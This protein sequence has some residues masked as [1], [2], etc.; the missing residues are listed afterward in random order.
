[1]NIPMGR[2][3]ATAAKG[4]WVQV[5]KHV[6]FFL[7]Q[8][9]HL[10][11]K[12]YPCALGDLVELDLKDKSVS[13]ILPRKNI[14]MRKRREKSDQLVVAN[15]SCVVLCVS[16]F[17][18]RFHIQ[19]VDRVVAGLM[20]QSIPVEILITKKDLL[21]AQYLEWVIL[22]QNYMK[23]Y[24]HQE[25]KTL[26][27][28][29]EVQAHQFVQTIGVT[30]E[31]PVL[32]FIGPTG[33]GKSTLIQS[34]TGE[35]LEISEV[36]VKTGKGRHTTTQPQLYV[37]GDTYLADCPGIKTWFPNAE[38]L[39]ECFQDLLV[40]PVGFKPT[41]EDIAAFEED[42]SQGSISDYWRHC[43]DE[44]HL[45]IGKQRYNSYFSIIEESLKG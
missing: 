36:N 35:R 11:Q 13:N 26:D 22:Y 8:G 2:V 16:F 4:V 45:M 37:W 5:E 41:E 28:K 14:V 25:I 15:V 34:I 27:A 31:L 21:D 42:P 10:N 24:C 40:A 18:D 7:F 17:K 32:A 43:P 6:G 1:M 12:L 3:M 20:Q 23:K 44:G 29:N 19:F 9:K 39:I 38:H 33:V 30:Q